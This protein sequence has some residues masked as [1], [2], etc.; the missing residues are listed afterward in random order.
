MILSTGKSIQNFMECYIDTKEKL[1]VLCRTLLKRKVIAVD[2]EFI[3]EKTYWPQLCLIQVSDG[4]KDYCIDP[5]AP[6][7]DLSLFSEVLDCPSVLKLFHAARQDIE[8]FFH[9]NHKIPAPVFDTQVAGMV[10]GL[11]DA[12]SYQGIVNIF[13]H[14]QITKEMR[15]S[16][17][18]KRPLTADQI[19]YALN[20]VHYLIPVYEKIQAVLEKK[21]RAS[22]MQDEMQVLLSPDT[23]DPDPMSLWKKIKIN[24]KKPIVFKTLQMLTAWREIQ[25]QRADKPRRSM[26]KDDA[27]IELAMA[28]PTSL[29][30]LKSLRGMSAG[31]FPKSTRGQEIIDLIK[32]VSLTPEEEKAFSFSAAP[33]RQVVCHGCV[34][35]LRLLLDCVGEAEQVAPKIICHADDLPQIAAEGKNADVP[36][37]KG[38]RFEIF[39]RYA[40]KLTEGK[41][42]LFFDPVE[43]KMKITEKI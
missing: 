25:A 22:W 9:M 17:W 29:E 21:N 2:T 3:R 16:D 18:S 8:I 10:I 14:A 26:L 23:Y 37:M 19:K 30:A 7:M 13:L 20:D 41:I 43:Q 1:S 42:G 36:A 38:W 12:V 40:L 5:L 27:L 35:A 15:F 34:E 33:K 4:E 31:H 11:G 6:D 24:T 28:R 39:G 32:N